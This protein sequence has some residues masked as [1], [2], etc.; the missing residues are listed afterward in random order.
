M[1]L[2]SPEKLVSFSRYLNS[3]LGCLVVLKNSNISGSRGNHTL[4][5]GQLLEYN[6]RNF[7]LEN[8]YTKGDGVNISRAFSKK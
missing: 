8:V 7:A 1:L 3:C 6:M 5:F 2:I 4:K